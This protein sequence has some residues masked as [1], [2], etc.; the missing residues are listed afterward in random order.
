[1]PISIRGGDMG[2][3][4]REILLQCDVAVWIASVR[5]E[6]PVQTEHM[7]LDSQDFTEPAPPDQFHVVVQETLSTLALVCW[8]VWNPDVAD[9]GI[10]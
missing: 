1:M 6:S 8:A 10:R 4:D 9:R 7:T 2:E 5:S 3:L